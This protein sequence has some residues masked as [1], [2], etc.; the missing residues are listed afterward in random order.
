LAVSI[1]G[2]LSA[3]D[4]RRRLNPWVAPPIIGAATFQKE[5]KA[6]E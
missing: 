5:P 4:A 3:P 1:A 2:N 6:A